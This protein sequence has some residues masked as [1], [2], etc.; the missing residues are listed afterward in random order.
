MRECSKLRPSSNL[1][2]IIVFLML[3]TPFGEI[4]ALVKHYEIKYI[5]GAGASGA[6]FCGID[7]KT[8]ETYAAKFVPREY[9]KDKIEMQH[10]ESEL[11]VFERL[12][13]PNIAKYKETIYLDNY[14]VIF[15]EMLFGGTMNQFIASA[16]H[17]NQAVLLRIA[18]EIC[19]ALE[20][21]HKRG[22][23]HRDIKPENIAFDAQ[24]HAKIIDFGLCIQTKEKSSMACGTPFYIAPEV[25][26]ESSYDG[27]K[28]DMWAFGITMYKLATGRFP[29]KQMTPKKFLEVLWDIQKYIHVDIEGDLGK[30]IRSCLVVDQKER[31]TAK[32]LLQSGLFDGAEKTIPHNHLPHLGKS[33]SSITCRKASMFTVRNSIMP[34]GLVDATSLKSAKSLIF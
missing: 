16:T 28:A 10:F 11:R 22:I 9:L 5:I 25:I 27:A 13:H 21:L 19:S 15:M 18:K 7:T 29:F 34:R 1:F 31:A 14:I 3:S 24:M 32:Q 4:P 23:S 8:K 2:F 30:I 26:Y 33:R 20:Y 12:D 17:V 6:V